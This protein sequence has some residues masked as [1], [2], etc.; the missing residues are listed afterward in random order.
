MDVLVTGGAGYIGSGLLLKL[1]RELPDVTITSLD[2]L[3]TG[4][5]CH[6]NHLKKDKRYRLLVGDVREKSDLK[7][8]ITEDTAVVVHMAAM[9]GLELCRKQPKKAID[10]NIYGAHLLLE[11]AVSKNVER[12]IFTS[13]AAVYGT[14]QQ[15][16]VAE[17]HP[18]KPIN[19]YGVTKVAAEQLINASHMAHGLATTIVRL[20]N[21]YGLSAYTRLNSVIPRFVWQAVNNEPLTIR[22]DG[23]Q[24][25]DFVHVHDVIDAVIR[26]IKAQKQAVA[27]ETFNIGGEA[28]TVNQ[29]A[30][31]V[32][33]EAEQRLGKKILKIFVPLEPDEVYTPSF[34][35][36]YRKAYER[37]GYVPKR[38]VSQGVPELF[39]YALN[40]KRQETQQAKKTCMS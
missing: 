6:V 21:V 33:Q 31:T 15:Q 9:P 5:Y 39:D 4:D 36:D 16:P 24:Q 26:C 22:A 1:G 18:L 3:S 29:I 19:L 30:E 25:R 8:A 37:I 13:S 27:G 35:Y 34:R 2:N 7:K 14:P 12:F 32:T 23:K 40:I 17:T 11:E 20:S 38:K 10:T 28:L